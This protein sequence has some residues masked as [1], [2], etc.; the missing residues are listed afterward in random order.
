[1]LQG[2]VW[3][4][5]MIRDRIENYIRGWFIGN[6]EPSILKTKEF[7][8]A[9]ISH[10]KDEKIPL[11]Y[12][13]ELEEYNVLLSGSMI[14]NNETLSEGDIFVLVRK[15]VVDVTVLEDSKVLCIK[16]PSIPEDK[17]CIK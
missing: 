13:S 6:F 8:V 5:I 14:V 17:T 12:H 4:S 3:Q 10:H 16:V 15:E 7:E 2:Y 11:H 9:I 1:M